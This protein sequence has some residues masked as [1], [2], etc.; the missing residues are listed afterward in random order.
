MS[1]NAFSEI[2]DFTIK[3]MSFPFLFFVQTW[4][5]KE[6][7]NVLFPRILA[8]RSSFWIVGYT[9]SRQ[10]FVWIVQNRRKHWKFIFCQLQILFR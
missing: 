1:V 8:A 4:H 3:I 9:K 2:C 10:D 7:E 6:L 5:G